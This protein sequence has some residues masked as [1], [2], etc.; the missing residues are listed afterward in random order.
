MSLFL[1]IHGGREERFA[2]DTSRLARSH[3]LP[4]LGT[5]QASNV[6]TQKGGENRTEI[7]SGPAAAG[8]FG[9]RGCGDFEIGGAGDDLVRE[10]ILDFD[11]ERVVAGREQGERQ[12]TI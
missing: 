4:P 3:I 6:I 10:V 7:R 11:F 12:L 8:L 2:L 9:G 5:V 1:E